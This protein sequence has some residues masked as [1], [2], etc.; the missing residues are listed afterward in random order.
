M[1]NVAA[2]DVATWCLDD[3]QF[4]WRAYRQSPNERTEC[5]RATVRGRQR[6]GPGLYLHSLFLDSDQLRQN[7]TYSFCEVTSLTSQAASPRPLFTLNRGHWSIEAMHQILDRSFDEDRSRMRTGCGSQTITRLRRFNHTCDE[8]G[9]SVGAPSG[10][11]GP[12]T[13]SGRDQPGGLHRDAACGESRSP[14]SGVPEVDGTSSAGLTHRA[15]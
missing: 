1:H 6:I 8:R 14:R 10:R 2:S 12:V 11:S 9:G 13:A 5:S 3:R 15:A 4:A 7:R